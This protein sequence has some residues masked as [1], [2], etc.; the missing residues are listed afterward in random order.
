MSTPSCHYQYQKRKIT[1]NCP[2]YNNVCSYGI[3]S[4]SQER[5]RKSHGKRVISVRAIEVL[6]YTTICLPVQGDNPLALVSGL[7]PTQA[8]KLNNFY[9]TLISVDLAQYD[10]FHAIVNEFW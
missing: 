1:L 5:F 9:T 6:L 2:K 10:I 8:D 7:S 4:P 3:F